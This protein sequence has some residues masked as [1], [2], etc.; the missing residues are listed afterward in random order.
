MQMKA[1]FFQEVLKCQ[2]D[3]ADN[4]GF[5]PCCLMFVHSY[6]NCALAPVTSQVSVSLLL[7][8]LVS[9]WRFFLAIPGTGG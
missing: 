5:W 2:M 6:H 7:K 8:V 9:V 3:S 4:C 1:I